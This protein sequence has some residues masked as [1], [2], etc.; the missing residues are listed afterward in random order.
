MSIFGEETGRK[1]RISDRVLRPKIL[2]AI[3]LVLAFS[4]AILNL[5][6]QY[7]A[8]NVADRGKNQPAVLGTQS[9]GGNSDNSTT[10]TSVV[11]GNNNNQSQAQKQTL[12]QF[13]QIP[14][15]SL[16]AGDIVIEKDGDL[17]IAKNVIDAQNI[18]RHAI[19]NGDLAT[20]SVTSRVLADNSVESQ[21][22]A[23]YLDIRELQVKDKI[24][25][26]TLDL[27]TNVITD[28]QM[29]GNWNF[30]EGN[31]TTSGTIT[32]GTISG[33]LQGGFAPSGDVNM[34]GHVLTDI[35]NSGTGFNS[36]GGLTLANALTVSS[37]GADITGN[38]NIYG[39]LDVSGNLT[40][41]NILYGLSGTVNR[42]TIGTGQSPTIDIAGDYAGQT[43]I[44]TLGTISSGTWEGSA[45]GVPYGGTGTSTFV[46]NYVLKGN[47]TGAL[48]SSLIYDNG[49]DIGIGTANPGANLEVD[50][51]SLFDGNAQFDNFVGMGN[52]YQAVTTEA[53]LITA[54][55]TQSN[56]LVTKSL[57]L[58]ANL[59]TSCNLA[60]AYGAQ[61]NLN[62]YTLTISGPFQAGTYQVFTGSGSVLMPNQQ[63][64]IAD[65]WEA[66]VSPGTTDMTA[67]IQAAI[68]A[69]YEHT[70]Y[71]PDSAYL[72]NSTL[73]AGQIQSGQQNLTGFTL[74]GAG[75]GATSLEAGNSLGGLPMIRLLNA[76][77]CFIEDMTIVGNSDYPPAAA[78]DSYVDNP[79]SIGSSPSDNTYRDLAIGTGSLNGFVNAIVYD[80]AS[81]YDQD[82][83]E[84]IIERV[85]TYNIKNYGV[86][87]DMV[88][89]LQNRITDSQIEGGTAAVASN[90]GNFLIDNTVV[91]SNTWLFYIG[92]GD[93]EHDWEVSNCTSEDGA[94][95]LYVDPNA[96]T[97]GHA[98]FSISNS[99]FKSGASSDTAIDIESPVFTLNIYGSHIAEG[100][101]T[102]NCTLKGPANFTSSTLGFSEINYSGNL[103]LVG[104]DFTGNASLNP[105]ATGKLA[106]NIMNSGLGLASGY[107]PPYVLPAGGLINQ[108]PNDLND[109]WGLGSV[110]TDGRN[111]LTSYSDYGGT[112]QSAQILE[113]DG[114]VVSLGPAS[115]SLSYGERGNMFL[116]PTQGTIVTT[117]F[118]VGASFPYQGSP[119]Q[120]FEILTPSTG[121]V[122]NTIDLATYS[123]ASNFFGGTR[124]SMRFTGYDLQF[125]VDGSSGK[126][127]PG[128]EVMRISNSGNVGIGTTSPGAK[129]EVSGGDIIGDRYILIG[130]ASGQLLRNSGSALELTTYDQSAFADFHAKNIQAQLGGSFGVNGNTTIL[131]AGESNVS[132]LAFKG[133][134]TSN[135]IGQSNILDLYRPNT[136]LAYPQ[137]A[138]FSL[139]E[140]ANGSGPST[141]LD[142]SMTNSATNGVPDA[143]IMTLQANGNVGIGT[144]S[145]G[146]KLDV[147][148]G[149]NAGS[150]NITV[151]GSAA[152]NISANQVYCNNSSNCLFN[153][154]GTGQT[155]IGNS[156]ALTQI[157]GATLS[158]SGSA[159]TV[160]I[161]TGSV[162]PGSNLTV[163]GNAAIGYSSFQ[164]A[165]TNGMIV[166]GDVG[167]GTTNPTHALEVT[168]DVEVSG[169]FIQ[170]G[171]NLT[172]PDYVFQPTYNLMPLDQ[173]QN[174]VETNSHLPGVPSE[175]DIQK[176]GLNT[177]NMILDL[178][179][180]TE[181]NVLYI[182]GNHNDIQTLSQ[183]VSTNQQGE[184][185]DVASLQA[186]LATAQTTL[187]QQQ[188]VLSSLNDQA[189]STSSKIALIGTSLSQITGNQT[190]DESKLNAVSNTLDS[191][192]Q[193]IATL[194]TDLQTLENQMAT[195]QEANQAVLDFASALNPNSLIYKDA[196]GNLDL[197]QGQLK[198]AGG[199]VIETVKDQDPLFGTATIPAG[200]SQVTVTNANVEATSLINLTL[201][202]DP[203]NLVTLYV[204]SR[205]AGEFTISLKGTATTDITISW[206]IM[207]TD[208]TGAETPAPATATGATSATSSDPASATP[209][210]TTSSSTAT[211]T[212][213]A[214]TNTTSPN[215]PPVPGATS[216]TEAN[217]QSTDTSASG[218]TTS[219][220]PTSGA[221]TPTTSSSSSASSS[222]GTGQTTPSSATLETATGQASSLNPT[223]TSTTTTSAA[224][225]T[226]QP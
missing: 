46:S 209:T 32:A 220:T 207:Q 104:N 83:S 63:E 55:D 49:T 4:L 93:Q 89:S 213:P 65:W 156:T 159:H 21:N 62:G 73:I 54:A 68:T 224:S 169:N 193:T 127:N 66:N 98:T 34:A 157:S 38:S 22:L 36:L 211:T 51:T 180:Q 74:E 214:P 52:S 61:I 122:S 221:S 146:Y 166:S 184:A 14:G 154:S 26:G 163:V 37:G 161:G 149:I 76:N 16:Q 124:P 143:T 176:N 113:A 217:T 138:S 126:N 199:F 189:L 10:G 152:L 1:K 17:F 25:A 142:I 155:I 140:Y 67:G 218:N 197:G 119:S 192:A 70:V 147:Y 23:H 136:G 170:N 72:I 139:G 200:K 167:I 144:T 186:S 105:S 204:S 106:V 116:D 201:E 133:A 85:H 123:T 226:S 148:G 56:V 118:E 187:A 12:A 117:P 205:K 50:G 29:H 20:N 35:G 71:L 114:M 131:A 92:A 212:T 129:L 82:N 100:A 2:L 175:A 3:L 179:Q 97:G 90:G 48:A 168:G 191:Q 87:S 77:H 57:T 9:Q 195:L 145:P 172:V 178:L 5:P 222:S 137:V 112:S 101:N 13:F 80:C 120:D 160:G 128:N 162:V 183:L 210:D 173:L 91:D 43:S 64:V 111:V 153:Y 75:I 174:Y 177:G 94:G 78:I 47:G 171:T 99:N 203:G 69:A 95:I 125:R 8:T 223:Q 208:G 150:G 196:A 107:H 194:Q 108:N 164:T 81:G 44:T 79:G 41:P 30:R 182:L 15:D 58:H 24:K 188:S 11:I 185:A 141:R 198:T 84:N 102:A 31:L 109:Y 42:V 33:S 165:P 206:W 28:G 181:Q 86:W 103:T 18:E 45:I 190:T 225:S 202:S 158:V 6:A 88:N 151:G 135:T 216:I 132:A 96:T 59:T 215:S 27:G 7:H 121:G 40:A 39:G 130:G 60:I 115:N 110:S 19:T 219:P 53:Q 134:A